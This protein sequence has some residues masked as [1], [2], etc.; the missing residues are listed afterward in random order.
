MTRLRAAALTVATI[1]AVT[2]VTT[3]PAASFGLPGGWNLPDTMAALALNDDYR[4]AWMLDLMLVGPVEG[5]TTDDFC[6]GVFLTAS[7]GTELDLKFRSVSYRLAPSGWG[8]EAITTECTTSHSYTAREQVVLEVGQ[9]RSTAN[10]GTCRYRWGYSSWNWTGDT[11]NTW[12][13]PLTVTVPQRVIYYVCSAWIPGTNDFEFTPPNPT[14]EPC[15]PESDGWATM[16]RVRA[17]TVARNL[18]EGLPDLKTLV[19]PWLRPAEGAPEAEAEP[20]PSTAT[21]A[22][23]H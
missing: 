23:D 7:D 10:W 22:A 5:I 8:V 9:C 18:P 20:P 11:L 15:H 21:P 16:N 4:F 19:R 17:R 12:D 6:D 3:A 13:G 1:T 14:T 2:V